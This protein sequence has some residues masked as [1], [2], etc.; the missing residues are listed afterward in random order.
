MT[1]TEIPYQSEEGTYVAPASGGDQGDGDNVGGGRGLHG[2]LRRPVALLSA[3]AVMGLTA[4]GVI[5]L[6]TL[7]GSGPT[8]VAASGV[9]MTGPAGGGGLKV[10]GGT[11]T[12]SNV[13]LGAKSY[14]LDEGGEL[15]SE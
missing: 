3:A 12:A 14:R 10:S 7:Y 11:G 6:G 1:T 9:G 5:T 15:V 4:L 8:S 13:S 2:L